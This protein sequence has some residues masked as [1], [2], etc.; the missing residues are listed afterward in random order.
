MALVDLE[1]G[2]NE[3]EFKQRLTMK[4]VRSRVIFVVANIE[5][6]RRL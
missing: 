1:K 2:L 3:N 5:F 6:Y 4:E